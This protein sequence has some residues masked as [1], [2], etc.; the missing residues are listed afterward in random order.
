MLLVAACQPQLVPVEVTRLVSDE[1]VGETAVAPASEVIEV[2]RL[3]TEVITREVEVPVTIEVTRPPLGSPERPIQILFPPVTD[4]QVIARRAAPFT[5]FLAAETGF[6]FTIGIL[7]SEQAVVDVM[8]RAP[9]DTI[10]VLSPVGYALLDEQ[11]GAAPAV[12][13]VTPNG[14]SWEAG[15]IVV[16][17]D[18]GITQLADLDGL[19][20]AV[21][22][23]TSI[24]RYFYFRALL[25]AEGVTAAEVVVPGDN[26]A[27][28]AVLDGE[29]DFATG[30]F[31]PPILPFDQRPWEYGEDDPEIWRQTGVAPSRSGIGFIVVNGAPEN[32]GYRVRDARSGIFDIARGVFIETEILLLSAPIPVETIVYGA[33]FPVLL[34]NRLTPMFTEFAASEMCRESLCALDLYEWAGLQPVVDDAFDPLRD[35]FAGLSLSPADLLE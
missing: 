32:G 2:T 16:R 8:C 11:C 4:A 13:G 15:M 3:V 7:D 33:D 5:D 22:D 17:R 24:P 31:V 6:A 25:A 21:P 35:I 9:G 12:V 10:G 29:A 27:L 30:A 20:W 1:V 34:A 19:R 26:T 18:S 23:E 28:L 14:Q